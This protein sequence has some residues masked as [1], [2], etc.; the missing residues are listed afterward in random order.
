MPK[1]KGKEYKYTAEGIMQFSS[2][3]IDDLSDPKNRYNAKNKKDQKKLE[4]LYSLFGKAKFAKSSSKSGK[5]NLT[6]KQKNKLA[7]MERK[8]YL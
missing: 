5:V 6:S 1:Y 7:T 8:G 3:K 4:N 2:K